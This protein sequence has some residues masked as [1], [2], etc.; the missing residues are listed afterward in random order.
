MGAPVSAVAALTFLMRMLNEPA[1]TALTT[2]IDTAKTDAQKVVTD[3][4]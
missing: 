2:K 4:T 1:A 3:L